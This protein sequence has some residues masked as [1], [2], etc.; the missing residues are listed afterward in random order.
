MGTDN[1][2]VRH[3]MQAA[4]ARVKARELRGTQ[5]GYYTALT[6]LAGARQAARHVNLELAGSRVAVEG[7]GKVGAPLAELLAAAGAR[8]VAVSTSCGAIYRRQGLDV[9]RLN[10]LAAEV[11]SRLVDRY[12]GGERL[13]REAL[14]E[15]PADLLCPCARHNSLH[16]GNA[17]RVKARIVCPGANNPV[18]PEAE[19][20]LFDRGILCLPDF[21][22]NSGG[23]LG[24]TMEFASIGR[25][26]IAAFMD[27]EIGGRIARLL[28]EAHRKRVLPREIAVPMALRR[29][30]QVRRNA[31]RPNLANRLFGIGLELYRQGLVP[32]ALVRPL[33]LPYFARALA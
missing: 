15:L 12:P 7:F 28:A 3:V 2:D 5:S 10:A 25:K 4:G 21:V 26:E 27:R 11:G 22:T 1:A 20:A 8:V 16:M 24:G 23:V 14:L 6:V 17:A 13:E 33:A 18:T 31:G 19:L 29:H 9:R 30:E 32:G